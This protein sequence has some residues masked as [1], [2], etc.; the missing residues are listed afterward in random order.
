M[1]IAVGVAV[2]MVETTENGVIV[3]L[4]WCYIMSIIKLVHQFRVCVVIAEC[5]IAVACLILTAISM[6]SVGV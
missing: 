4:N 6:P 2:G 3:E 5:T 1:I